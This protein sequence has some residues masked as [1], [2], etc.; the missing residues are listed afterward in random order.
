[1]AVS[2]TVRFTWMFA[3]GERRQAAVGHV[4]VH[5]R[6]HVVVGPALENRQAGALA[7]GVGQDLGRLIGAA[8]LEDA[9]RD[10]QDQRHDHGRLDQRRTALTAHPLLHNVTM[11]D[12]RVPMAMAGP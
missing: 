7:R 8:E 6:A 9:D 5:A 12:N 2:V 11:K 3:V 10:Q 4:L 1:M